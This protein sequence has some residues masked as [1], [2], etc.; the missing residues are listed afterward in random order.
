MP[1]KSGESVISWANLPVGVPSCSSPPC[2]SPPCPD[3]PV[4]CP[5]FGFDR[6]NNRIVHYHKLD[7]NL[8]HRQAII[9][10]SEV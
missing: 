3:P 4:V 10:F 8:I 5:G 9:L 2:H 6:S 1:W 7:L